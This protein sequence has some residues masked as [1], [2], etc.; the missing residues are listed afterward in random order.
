MHALSYGGAHAVRRAI[1]NQNGDGQYER[2][3]RTP[4]QDIWTIQT[5]DGLGVVFLDGHATGHVSI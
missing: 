1:K 2:I 5:G 3:Y 4:G